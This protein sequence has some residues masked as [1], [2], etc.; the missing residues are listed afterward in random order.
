V[1]RHAKGDARL[2]RLSRTARY[3]IVACCA[4][5]ALTACASAQPGTY[6]PAELECRAR[7]LE[8]RETDFVVDAT[9]A[10]WVIHSDQASTVTYSQAKYSHAV[11]FR[12]QCPSRP[13][14]CDYVFKVAS[15]L[16][17]EDLAK[18]YFRREVD[19]ALS[20]FEAIEIGPIAFTNADEYVFRGCRFDSGGCQWFF[21]YGVVVV[22]VLYTFSGRPDGVLIETVLKSLDARWRP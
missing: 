11:R 18:D 17:N 5:V 22:N 1:L 20:G 14:E 8:I 4:A 16:D 6:Q 21:R 19:S 2:D 12:Q 3:L 10:S 15:A 13:T 9:G 7:K